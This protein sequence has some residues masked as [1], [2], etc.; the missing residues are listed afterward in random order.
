[1]D[2]HIRWRAAASILWPRR[3]LS[4]RPRLAAS[5]MRWRDTWP[6]RSVQ[7]ICRVTGG[8]FRASAGEFVQLF[9]NSAPSLAARRQLQRR[10]PAFRLPECSAASARRVRSS[11]RTFYQPA[12]SFRRATFRLPDGGRALFVLA[13]RFPGGEF[14]P[15][16]LASPARWRHAPPPMIHERAEKK[17]LASE[18]ELG[19]SRRVHSVA[20]ALTRAARRMRGQ[21]LH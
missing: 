13:P 21:A 16:R 11:R 8:P 18:L 3:A 6:R 15:G 17:R 20:S 5:G 10:R 19:S 4:H 14:A 7:V 12:A 1:M 2:A 9:A